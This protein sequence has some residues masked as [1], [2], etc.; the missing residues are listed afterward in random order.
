MAGSGV[1]YWNLARVLG[2]HAPVILAIPGSTDLAPPDGVE[3]IA[4]NNA[5]QTQSGRR[6]AELIAEHDIAIAQHLPYL[7]ADPEQFTDTLLVVDLY[8]PWILEKLEYARIDPERG[9]PNRRDDVEILNRLLTLGDFFICASE[10]QRD[11]WLGALAVNDRL[12]LEHAQKGPELR[13]LIDVVGFGLPE[14]RPM[15]KGPGPRDIFP[16]LGRSTS[17]VLWN[18]GLWNWLDPMTAIRA[19]DLL[20]ERGIDIALI[21]MGTQ[22]PGAQVAD[23]RVVE[24]A[25]TLA[26]ELELIDSAVFFNDWVPYDERQTWLLQSAATLSLHQATVESRYAYRTRVLD[27]LWCGVPIV[28]SRGDVLAEIVE[29]DGLGRTVPPG[30]PG[31]V[32]EALEAVLERDEQHRL[33]ERITRVARDYTWE[34]VAQPLVDFCLHP[35]VKASPEPPADQQYIQKLERLYTETAEYARRLERVLAERDVQ[36]SMV[37]RSSDGGK[38]A[39]LANL[40]RRRLGK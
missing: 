27:N 32:A 35:P 6:L 22:S 12:T 39:R 40:V 20:R 3:I 10:R 17:I 28:A 19:V 8:A 4:Y 15:P 11:F 18:G 36:T 26:T 33:R 2:P 25:K 30:D 5:D 9:E 38:I 21:F 16:T 24:D 13:S 7:Y 29:R 23:M 34:Q 1:R 31:A 14:S 37:P